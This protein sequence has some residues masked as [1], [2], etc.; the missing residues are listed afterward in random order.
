VTRWEPRAAEGPG[1]LNGLCH[2]SSSSRL[3]ILSRF[4]DMV[5]HRFDKVPTPARPPA[6]SCPHGAASSTLH[7]HWARFRRID[8]RMGDAPRRRMRE[9]RRAGGVAG[10]RTSVPA[11][12]RV[13]RPEPG[14]NRMQLGVCS[15]RQAWQALAAAA[16][17]RPAKFQ[18]RSA[19]LRAGA[20]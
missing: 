17:T 3:I 14:L 7:L 10:F 12:C 13:I 6:Y 11:G 1:G 18:P 19:G 20:A 5:G 16:V 2:Y 4:G 9:P 15:W 8:C